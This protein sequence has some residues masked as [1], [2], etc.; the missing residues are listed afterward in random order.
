MLSTWKAF[1]QDIKG[2]DEDLGQ[3]CSWLN[4]VICGFLL[5]IR[6]Q[7][8]EKD[9]EDTSV[10]YNPHPAE[11]PKIGEDTSKWLNG[12]KMLEFLERCVEQEETENTMGQEL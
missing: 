7:Y 4:Y 10:D 1:M 12:A 8:T 2:P 6:R 3:S 5:G 11:H 9:L